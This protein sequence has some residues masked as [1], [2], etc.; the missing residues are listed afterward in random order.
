MEKPKRK[1]VIL[2]LAVL[3]IALAIGF[4]VAYLSKDDVLYYFMIFSI[5]LSFGITM[6]WLQYLRERQG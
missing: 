1:E 6:F 5:S 3:W 4:I 2:W